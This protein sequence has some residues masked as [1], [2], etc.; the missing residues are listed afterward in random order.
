MR[1]A[2]LTIASVAAALVLISGTAHASTV[3]F[4]PSGGRTATGRFEVSSTGRVHG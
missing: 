1:K 3:R 2:V 4:S